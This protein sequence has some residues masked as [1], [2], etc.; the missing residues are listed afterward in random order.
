MKRL[1]LFARDIIPKDP[2]QLLFLAGSVLLFITMQLRCFPVF[3]DYAPDSN[4]FLGQ[5]HEDSFARAYQSWLLFSMLARLPIVFGGAAGLFICFW[6]GTR[7]VRR[8]LGFVCL[9]ALSGIVALCIRFLYLTQHSGFP[10]MSVL[11]QGSRKEAWVFSRIW[12]LGPAVHMSAVGIVLVIIFLSRLAMGVASLPL[13]LAQPEQG[14][15]PQDETW[16][17]IC[18]FIWIAIAAVSIIGIPE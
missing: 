16:K 10:Y 13:S 11:Q 17:R 14:P 2:T 15:S 9:P 7:P 1:I 4:T 3:T 8:I 12:S 5:P 18:I 6:P